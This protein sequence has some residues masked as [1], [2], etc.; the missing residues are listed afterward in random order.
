MR[1]LILSP[2]R[3]RVRRRPRMPTSRARE[4]HLDL[5]PSLQPERER[6][7]TVDHPLSISLRL[8]GAVDVSHQLVLGHSEERGQA[9]PRRCFRAK[10]PAS[11]DVCPPRTKRST[12]GCRVDPV[13]VGVRQT[14]G[15]QVGG[16]VRPWVRLTAWPNQPLHERWMAAAVLKCCWIL[17][18]RAPLARL[19]GRDRS[20][21]VGEVILDRRFHGGPPGL[22]LLT[23][24]NRQAGSC[25]SSGPDRSGKDVASASRRSPATRRRH[26]HQIEVVWTGRLTNRPTIRLFSRTGGTSM[27]DSASSVA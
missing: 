3:R 23:E 15:Q 27:E 13:I 6:T 8:P 2:R 5:L 21:L 22:R 17:E 10:V 7:A 11:H 19:I 16:H 26:G 18:R 12:N 25:Q 24:P 20:G 1:A 14:L 9:R 4:A